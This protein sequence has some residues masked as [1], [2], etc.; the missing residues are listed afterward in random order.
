MNTLRVG[1]DLQYVLREAVVGDREQVV[2]LVRGVLDEF[3]MRWDPTGADAQ[4]VAM[5][6]SYVDAGGRFFVVVAPAGT[7]V[8]TLG[9][10]PV[11]ATL[12]ELRKMYLLPST[13]GQ[14]I[15]RTLVQYAIDWARLAG[16]SRIELETAA[17]LAAAM[18]LY[19]KMGFEP[20]GAASCQ[21]ACEFR[22]RLDLHDTNTGTQL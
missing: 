7:I 19:K 12:I 17:S 10:M 11:S 5:P 13:R 18:A 15:G 6:D 22:L 3:A 21:S 8:G 4:V 1:T 9:M 14:G 16:F 20:M 2:N